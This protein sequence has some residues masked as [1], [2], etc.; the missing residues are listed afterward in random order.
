MK[1]LAYSGNGALELI[2]CTA[3]PPGPAEVQIA[4]KLTG[5]CG[6][7]LHALHG[8]MD[9]RMTFPQVLGHEM[10]GAV[11]A[12][13]VDVGTSFHEGD[14]VT[15]MP[16]VWCGQCHAC[17]AGNQHVC[18]RLVFIGLD[19]DGSLQELWTVPAS[20]VIR[21]PA[22]MTPEQGV[23][24]E[25]VAVAHHDV[26]R[27]RLRSGEHAVV[28]GAGPIGLMI[29]LV[30]RARGAE[31]TVV[32]IDPRRR[33]RAEAA[34]FVVIDPSSE[35]VE[36]HVA[37]TTQ[38]AGAEVVFEVSGSAGGVATAVPLLAVRGRLV[39][40]GVH[41]EPRLVDLHR[42][43]W[44]ELELVGA[45]VY[46]RSDFE[47]SIGLLTDRVVTPEQL[48]SDVYPLAEGA[49]AFERLQRGDGAMKVVIESGDQTRP[50]SA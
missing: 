12:V 4:V 5:I 26:G 35:D 43:F 27:A 47:A 9:Q 31:V 46:Q 33:A 49:Q 40:V 28:I 6:T 8:V 30:A 36:A 2:E 7:D 48:I 11:H 17:R 34:G 45:R 23:L 24:V 16:L 3:A 10:V 1:K 50:Q 18:Q 19:V 15:V 29:A 14:L 39:V 22:G 20:V 25:P 44:R 13:G 42:V 32:E 21:L 38:D 37:A 41:P